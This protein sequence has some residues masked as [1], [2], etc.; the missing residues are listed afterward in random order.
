MRRREGGVA[1]FWVSVEPTW[2]GAAPFQG[3]AEIPARLL[4]PWPPVLRAWRID[5]MI[6]DYVAY[7]APWAYGPL[8]PGEEH[9][10][11]PR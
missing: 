10:S 3:V 6:R 1:R 5:R 2:P 9:P 7:Q 4:P 8:A 11:A